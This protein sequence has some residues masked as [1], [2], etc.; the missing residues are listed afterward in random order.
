MK[1]GACILDWKLSSERQ[2][3]ENR[4]GGSHMSTEGRTVHVY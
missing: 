1:F 4:F 2:F 3:R